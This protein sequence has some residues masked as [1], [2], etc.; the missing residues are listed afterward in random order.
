M[1][2]KF[3][4]GGCSTN[5]DGNIRRTQRRILRELEIIDLTG[6]D[7]EEYETPPATRRRF[8]LVTPPFTMEY[9]PLS[10]APPGSQRNVVR[11]TPRRSRPAPPSPPP[12]KQE[13]EILEY[14]PEQPTC[15]HNDVVVCPQRGYLF[16]AFLYTAAS[17]YLNMSDTVP[18]DSLDFGWI[19]D[20]ELGD[21]W[22]IK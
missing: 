20:L 4:T 15:S 5:G 7:D 8:N 9:E 11:P 16:I 6:D 19:D 10:L 14:V 17:N 22:E 18:V 1:V 13:T 21:P 3:Q 12:P 2:R